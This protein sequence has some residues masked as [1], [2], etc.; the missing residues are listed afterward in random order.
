MSENEEVWRSIRFCWMV[1]V[2]L[3]VCVVEI[4]VD[5]DGIFFLTREL[6]VYVLHAAS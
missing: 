4:F 1:G 3:C 6:F 5:L 2:F